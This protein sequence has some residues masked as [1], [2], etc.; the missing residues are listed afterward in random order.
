MDIIEKVVKASPVRTKR[1]LKSIPTPS[2]A[3]QFTNEVALALFLDLKLTKQ[4]YIQLRLRAIEKVSNMYP[5]YH[6]ITAAKMDCLPSKDTITNNHT[7]FGR[8]RTTIS[9]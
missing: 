4:Q 5:A 3:K 2:D 9:T 8:G 7:N 6:H 1:I